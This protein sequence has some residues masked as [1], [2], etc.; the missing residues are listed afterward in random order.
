MPKSNRKAKPFIMKIRF[1][2]I[3]LLCLSLLCFWTQNAQAQTKFINPV[4]I[5]YPVE[6]PDWRLDII[7][8]VHNFDPNGAVDMVIDQSNGD[9][10]FL[11]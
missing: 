3:S 6:G 1:T 2:F 4:P 9:R 10:F 8:T 7:D 5:P 11:T